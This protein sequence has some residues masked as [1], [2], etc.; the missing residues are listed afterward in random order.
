[1]DRAHLVL[2]DSGGVQ[3]EAPGLGTPAIVMRDHTERTEAIDAGTA[4]LVGS[5][6]VRIVASV[7]ALLDDDAVWRRMATAANPF[8]DGHSCARI[9][10]V[11]IRDA[12]PPDQRER[13]SGGA[14][15]R[16]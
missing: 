16:F 1:M 8:G 7:S 9:A 15:A 4:M 2:T 5:D 14:E 12:G 10:E 13:G 3:E 6:P 11:L